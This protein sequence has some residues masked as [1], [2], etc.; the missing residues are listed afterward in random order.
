MSYEPYDAGKE[1]DS[2]ERTQQLSQ[3]QAQEGMN[4]LDGH[5][6][7][8]S[9][10]ADPNLD[11]DNSVGVDGL[12]NVSRLEIKLDLYNRLVITEV[13][14]ESTGK[15]TMLTNLKGTVLLDINQSAQYYNGIMFGCYLKQLKKLVKRRE[16]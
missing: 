16:N 9:F 14:N 8:V 13:I 2:E 4:G 3:E 10:E 1:Y 11:K 6:Q 15:Q 12:Q 7:N 5:L